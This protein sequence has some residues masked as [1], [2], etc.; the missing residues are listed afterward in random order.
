MASTSTQH[1]PPVPEEPPK[2]P[3][4]GPRPRLLLGVGLEDYFHVRAFEHLIGR[5]R[6]GRFEPR[7]EASTRRTLDLLDQYGA[8]TTFFVMGWVAE[9]MPALVREVA[10]RGHEVASQGMAHRTIHQFSR[11]TFREDAIRARSV[12]ED[13][14][15]RRVVGHRVP[16]FLGPDALWALDVL[17]DAGFAYD[18]SLR[19]LLGQ[20]S[21]EPWRRFVHDAG[22][23]VEVPVSTV[24]VGQWSLPVAAGNGFRQLPERLAREAVASWFRSYQAPFVSYFHVWELDPDQPRINAGS[25]LGRIRHYR[26]LDRM[27]DILSHYLQTCECTPI[28][29]HLGQWPAE[30][31]TRHVEP[32]SGPKRPVPA[33]VAAGRPPVTLVVPCYNEGLALNYLRNTLGEL[34]DELGPRWDLRFVF[35]DDGSSDDTHARLVDLF[36]GLEGHRVIRHETNRGVAAAILT[37]IR[38]ADTEIVA[39]IDCDCTYDP[40]ELRHMIP[41]LQD[42]VAMVTASPYHAQGQVLNVPTWRLGLSRGA[43]FLYQQILDQDLA[44]FTSCFRVYRKSAVEGLTLEEEGFL[45]VAEMLGRLALSGATIVEHPATLESRFFGHSK[46]KK[47]L[48]RLWKEKSKS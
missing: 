48:T 12:I 6:W 43:S 42:G 24:R 34:R 33:P 5:A 44:T 3:G 36:G 46:M 14:T 10:D 9:A 27:A 21:E 23:I 25:R 17:A 4:A 28:A 29:A 26:N 15:G 11:E 45:G 31:V 32:R 39:S 8:R 18:A 13:A 1:A 16:H 22:G 37:G 40:L 7:I 19:P 35:V 30:R 38:S 2:V 47:L 20:F 41:K